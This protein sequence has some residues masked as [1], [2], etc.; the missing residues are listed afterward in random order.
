MAFCK[1]SVKEGC[2][3]IQSELEMKMEG[4]QDHG[5]AKVKDNQVNESS[6]QREVQYLLQEIS[7]WRKELTRGL[8]NIV[9]SHVNIITE[10]IN[11]L[12]DEVGDLNTRLAAITQ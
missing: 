10:G 1:G 8:T 6:Y 12:S 9:D 7:S 3:D 11:N 2:D 4:I 5:K